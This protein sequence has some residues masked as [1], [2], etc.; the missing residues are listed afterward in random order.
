[1]IYPGKIIQFHARKR[2]LTAKEAGTSCHRLVLIQI[3]R[4]VYTRGGKKSEAIFFCQI[5]IDDGVSRSH[6]LPCVVDGWRASR[7]ATVARLLK[8]KSCLFDD[9][10]HCSHTY[11]SSLFEKSYAMT[12]KQQVY[13]RSLDSPPKGTSSHF[14]AALQLAA[15][16]VQPLRKGM[17]H[18]Y[19][20]NRNDT[21]IEKM[22]WLFL[23]ELGKLF[24]SLI[25]APSFV[26]EKKGGDEDGENVPVNPEA[27]FMFF[28]MLLDQFKLTKKP[29]DASNALQILLETI[30]KC[31]RTLPVTGE[32]WSSLLD[33]SGETFFC[34]F[35]LLFHISTIE[36]LHLPT[37]FSLLLIVSQ[38]NQELQ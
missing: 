7:K 29:K 11:F 9:G 31:C 35:S 18:F 12:S 25:S 22:E 1:M 21:T 3:L 5:E 34:S 14:L 20:Q 38:P 4:I 37:W 26:E 30:Q 24:Q 13:F 15:H 28:D 36:L 16:V 32:L 23:R 33:S 17:I 27:F 2:A 6:R 19:L 10:G 8:V